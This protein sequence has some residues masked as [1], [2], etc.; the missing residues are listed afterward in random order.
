MILVQ[1]TEVAGPSI[2]AVCPR[3]GL[4]AVDVLGFSIGGYIA[5]SFVLRYPDLA[6]R[7]VLV[8]TAPRNSELANDPGIQETPGD[9]PLKRYAQNVLTAATRVSEQLAKPLQS[10]EMAA[11]LAR[12]L[13]CTA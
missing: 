11:T 9:S 10:R 7:L 6:R 4:R 13:H 2:D 1:F 8:G 5:Q 12:V 3:F